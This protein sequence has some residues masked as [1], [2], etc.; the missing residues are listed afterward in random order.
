MVYVTY[1]IFAA[2]NSAQKILFINIEALIIEKDFRT[3][4]LY[5]LSHRFD[6]VSVKNMQNW[7]QK[8]VFFFSNFRQF[9]SQ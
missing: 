3:L 9:S 1:A 6:N 5:L 2:R 8:N 4:V 7:G